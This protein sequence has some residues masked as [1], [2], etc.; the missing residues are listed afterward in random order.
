M[1]SLDL[2]LKNIIKP[3]LGGSL[4]I[5]TFYGCDYAVPESAS[6][7]PSLSEVKKKE[8]F[9][10]FGLVDYITYSRPEEPLDIELGDVDG[11]GDLDIVVANFSGG[12]KIYENRM[13]QRS[14][15]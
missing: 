9:D 12:I 15:D 8:D 10:S 7:K 11:D 6:S 3:I 13:P 2:I 14:R 5:L 4:Y 1:K